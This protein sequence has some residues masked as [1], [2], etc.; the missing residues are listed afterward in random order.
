M[1]LEFNDRGVRFQYPEGW[2]LERE[3]GETSWT[4][5]VQS[6]QTAFLL[7]SVDEGMPSTE[8][9]AETALEALRSEY[10]DLEAEDHVDTLAG[11][12]AVGYDIQFFSFDLTNTCWMRSFY[13]ERGT[14]LVLWQA[15]D[16]ELEAYEPVLRAMCAS[17]EVD[18]E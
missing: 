1:P 2:R 7:I 9:V 17:L 8:D 6:P 11:Q 14:V 13:S 5:S 4:V 10:P 3:D 12:P 16:L 15:N 18:A